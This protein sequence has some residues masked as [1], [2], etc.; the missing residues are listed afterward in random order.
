ML[1]LLK[2]GIYHSVFT[3]LEW[4]PQ[5]LQQENSY[6]PHSKILWGEKMVDHL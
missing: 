5:V 3:A 6:K 4:K 2:A 1:N